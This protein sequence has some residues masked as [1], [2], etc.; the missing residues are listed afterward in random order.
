MLQSACNADNQ[1]VQNNP[2]I[3]YTIILAG[4]CAYAQQ[5]WCTARFTTSLRTYAIN[6]YAAD[7]PGVD[8]GSHVD[9]CVE[10]QPSGEYE[11][12]MRLQKLLTA[13][14]PKLDPDPV[15]V[16]GGVAKIKVAYNLV[17]L[18]G[19]PVECMT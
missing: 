16:A 9:L 2:L 15:G 12:Y 10:S 5:Q 1:I 8:V 6:S 11:A 7:V 18:A 3:L 17:L 13:D 19:I 4:I 14:F